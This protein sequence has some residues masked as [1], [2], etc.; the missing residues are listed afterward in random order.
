MRREMEKFRGYTPFIP[1]RYENHKAPV[2][3]MK[4]LWPSCFKTELLRNKQSLCAPA[5]I[6]DDGKR[7]TACKT[8]PESK[9]G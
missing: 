7:I 8:K 9:M 6:P 5:M 1:G 4:P 3:M 2:Q